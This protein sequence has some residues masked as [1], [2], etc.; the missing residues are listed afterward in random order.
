M[1]RLIVMIALAAF[2]LNGCGNTAV[3]EPSES[4]GA[5][6]EEGTLPGPP[7]G[8]LSLPQ[9]T[10]PETPPEETTPQGEITL[11]PEGTV[12][13]PT[14]AVSPPTEP[15]VPTQSNPQQSITP[16]PQSTVTLPQETSPAVTVPAPS[17]T[18]PHQQPPSLTNCNH[19]FQAVQGMD[20]GCV[21]AGY[22]D[23]R[24][25]KCGTVEQVIYQPLGHSFQEATCTTPPTCTRCGTTQGPPLGHRFTDGS[26][27]RCAEPDPTVRW[28]SILIKDNKNNPVSGVTVEVYIGEELSTPA[29]CHVS[30]GDGRLRFY[31]HN[32]SGQYKLELTQIPDGYTAGQTVYVYQ[33]DSGSIVLNANPVVLPE[34]H[35]KAAYKIGSTMGDFTLTDVDGNTYRL[36]ELLTRKKLVILN[37]WYCNCNPC[38]AEFPFFNNVYQRYGSQIEVLALNHIDSEDQIRQL[39]SQMGLQFPLLQENIGMKEGFGLTSYP[40]TVFIGEGGRIL[41]IQ[42]NDSFE[43]EEDLDMIIR[44]MLGL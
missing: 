4:P 32:H 11:P 16:P 17:V 13:L 19:Q 15:E 1:K 31:L 29:G 43:A 44:Q 2:L 26:C 23:Y 38:K 41:Q 22:V 30:D 37:F 21:E 3:E 27:S 10:H 5:V 24:C 8:E 18:V 14:D 40:A 12:P 36:S 20:P 25:T 33:A 35:S 34:D 39:R 42:K 9:Q 28:I 7:Q 6:T